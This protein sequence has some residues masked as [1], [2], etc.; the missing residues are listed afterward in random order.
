[1]NILDIT[2]IILGLVIIYNF[3]PRTN[4][5][6]FVPDKK[7]NV[8]ETDIDM[9]N[10]EEDPSKYIDK[11]L[12][13]RT[14][15]IINPYFLEV[16]F[17]QDY[18][19]TSNAFTLLSPDQRQIFNKSDM[20]IVN[21]DKPSSSE[22]KHLITKFI[23]E[24]NK[25]IKNHVSNEITLT[26][27]QD[28]TPEKKYKSGWDK[29]QEELGLPGSIYLDPA[30][31][32]PVKLIKVDHSEKYETEEEIKY[33]IF[34]II[35][36]KNVKDQMVLRVSFVIEK[37]DINLDREFF[38]KSKNTYETSVK[39]EEIFTLGFMTNH[40]FGEKTSRDKFYDFDGVSDGRMFSQKDIIKMLNKKRRDYEKE[41]HE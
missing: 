1:M 18:R 35:Q 23:K 7:S 40:S 33:V 34:L 8:S 10:F 15:N 12:R 39:I 4:T 31:K 36:K 20:P 19:D 26:S 41:C 37:K 6:Q 11:I 22:I 24:V 17:H 2:I 5:E 30:E 38:A 3:I 32:A 25:T 9:G 27:W 16:Q 13:S 29:Q 21:V 14:K 28:N